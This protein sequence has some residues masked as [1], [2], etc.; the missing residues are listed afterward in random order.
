MSHKHHHYDNEDVDPVSG[1]DR[2]EFLKLAGF[3]FAGAVLAG[4]QQGKVEKAIPFLIQPEEITPG[5]AYWYSTTCGG[6]NAGC[7]VLAKNRDGRPI[8]LEGNPM[9]PISRGGLC[10]IGQASILSL[11]DSHRLKNPLFD[12]KDATWDHVDEQVMLELQKIKSFGGVVRLLTGSINSPTTLAVIDR[13]LAS[14]P[15]SKHVQYSAISQSAILDAHKIT[16]GT[17]ALPRYYFDRAETIVSFDADFL[18]RWISPVEFTAGYRSGRTLAGTPPKFSHHT[19]FES[20]LSLTGSNADE[21]IPV[22]P[23]ELKQCAGRLAALLAG[24]AGRAI[25]MTAKLSEVLDG[26]IATLANR[27]WQSQGRSLVVCGSNDLQLQLLTNAI[28]QWLGNYNHTLSLDQ[29]SHQLREHDASLQ[30]LIDEVHT[31]KVS[32]LFVACDPVYDLPGGEKL[33]VSIAKIPLV[34]SFAE[35]LDETAVAARVVCPE[36]HFLEAWNDAEPVAGVVSITQPTI[37]PLMNTRTMSESLSGWIGQPQKAYDLLRTEWVKA[38]FKRQSAEP[39]FEKFWSKTLLDGFAIVA[40]SNKAKPNFDNSA[41]ESSLAA[42]SE[43]KDDGSTVLLLQTSFTMLD[44]RHAHNPWLHELPDPVTKIVWDNC[45]SLSSETAQR[46]G[47]SEGD[48]VQIT[49]NDSSAIE[50]PVH[51]QPGQHDGVVVVSLGYGRKGTDRFT[52]I[53]PEWLQ[54]RPTVAP[55]EVVG[56]N[57][58]PFSEFKNGA[59]SYSGRVVVLT[60]TGRSQSLVATQEYDSLYDPILFGKPSKERRPIVQETTLAAYASN[61]AAGSFHKPELD[62]M[63]PEDHRYTGHHWGMVVDLTACTGCS[64]CVVGC[65][66]ENNIPVVGK[67]EVRRNRELTWIRLDRYYDEADGEFSVSHQP[68]MC[69]HCGNAPCETVCPVLATVHNSEGLNQQVYNRCVGTRYCANN[70][71]YKIRRFNWFEYPRGDDM[72]KMV[73]NPDVTVRDRGVMEKCSFCIQRIQSAKIDAKN[74]GR[75]LKDGDIQPACAQ[76]CPAQA[77]AFG[78]MNDPQS[79]VSKRMKDKRYYRVLE[80]L[81]V[82]PSV[83]YM[84]LVR[85][86]EEKKKEP[87]H[88]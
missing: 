45:A 21:R 10:A 49:A 26:K 73:L 12:G 75:Q 15:D 67:D 20:R 76:S 74:E 54:A 16:H 46:L 19:Q 30:S 51:I 68:M 17:R 50:L 40:P 29:P 38:V 1:I 32:A 58:A 80:E 63:W 81:G 85:N 22:S 82:R 42:E 24:K 41:F 79:E 34:V 66:A 70:C 43:I 7:G 27:L 78:D 55:G 4:C 53:G 5:M 52:N 36:P 39:S 44:G 69:Q 11:Y 31:G 2:R 86:S 84:T 87:Q 64:A 56:R 13:F 23:A 28:N 8:K 48:L 37:Q 61:P 72:Q 59:L 88:G 6:C 35:R 60:A 25:P 14:F 18:G 65:Q 77:I 9:H 3:S 33:A 83:G 57:A 71:P 47:L 62:S